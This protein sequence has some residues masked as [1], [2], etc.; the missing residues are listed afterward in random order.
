MKRHHF[1]LFCL[2]LS[3]PTPLHAYW[4]KPSRAEKA[5]SQI[6]FHIKETEILCKLWLAPSESSFFPKSTSTPPS[7]SNQ[8]FDLIIETD[9]HYFLHGSI[10]RRISTP[11]KIPPLAVAASPPATPSSP[12][13]LHYIEITY[14]LSSD[15]RPKSLTIHPPSFDSSSTRPPS[16]GLLTFDRKIPLSEVLFF[17][18]AETI[19]LHPSDP[20][21]SF[22]KKN[23]SSRGLKN[24]VIT[25]LAPEKHEVKIQF[26]IRLKE[27]F[28]L[29]PELEKHFHDQ[30]FKKLTKESQ[31]LLS[32]QF[33]LQIDQKN[34]LLLPDSAQ[35]AC[36]TRNG[37]SFRLPDDLT[38]PASTFLALSYYTPYPDPQS[39]PTSVNLTLDNK[40][41]TSLGEI[42]G[43]TSDGITRSAYELTDVQ[44]SLFWSPSS[45]F[46][47]ANPLATPISIPASMEQP[48]LP[49]LAIILTCGTIALLISF[50]FHRS[51]FI[52]PRASL[53]AVHYSSSVS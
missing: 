32:S 17:T 13:F 8:E 33:T 27:L 39:F 5:S 40:L 30:Q 22:R 2:L 49:L 19:N 23:P 34:T 21:A 3:I 53:L 31:N 44:R 35:L 38:S 6:E 1:S 26:L 29:Y 24:P 14:P 36:L 4:L 16:L 51:K 12:P 52:P 7:S 42:L 43:I 28:T 11:S 10:T 25:F 9:E 37:V 48:S 20:W 46:Q 45:A 47:I 15:S 41:I 18:Q 50:I